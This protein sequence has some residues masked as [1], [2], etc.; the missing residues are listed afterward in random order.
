MRFGQTNPLRAA[1]GRMGVGV[2]LVLFGLVAVLAAPGTADKLMC[3]LV[4]FAGAGLFVAGM[5]Q[6]LREKAEY[7]EKE[8]NRQK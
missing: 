7:R 4:V 8:A 2:A 3:A 5:R 6:D 1:K